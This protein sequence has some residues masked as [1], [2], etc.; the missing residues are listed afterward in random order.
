MDFEPA[1]L[2]SSLLISCLGMGYFLYGKKAGR[3]IPL[4]AGIALS[5]FPFFVSSLWL[6]W[7]IAAAIMASAFYFRGM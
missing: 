7:G 5:A 2:F 6:M 3:M 1:Y 4:L